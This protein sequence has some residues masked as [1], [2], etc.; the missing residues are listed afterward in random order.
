[1]CHSGVAELRTAPLTNCDIIAILM[2]QSAPVPTWRSWLIPTIS[3]EPVISS[4]HV[5][6][7]ISSKQFPA[8]VKAHMV[9]ELKAN[10]DK[11]LKDSTVQ[12][13]DLAVAIF[14]DAYLPITVDANLIEEPLPP[15][16]S[17][18]LEPVTQ[19]SNF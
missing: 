15:G 13:A 8:R 3:S 19:L 9:P 10:M 12:N 18:L 17:P 7:Q 5:I 4:E 2:F 6:E 16:T 11:E 14:P 1:M